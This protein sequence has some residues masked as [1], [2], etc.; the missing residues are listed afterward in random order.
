M[1]R[2]PIGRLVGVIA[3]D[4]LLSPAAIPRDAA[5]GGPTPA[6][7]A[8]AGHDATLEAFLRYLAAGNFGGCAAAAAA[9]LLPPSPARRNSSWDR[10]ASRFPTSRPRTQLRGVSRVANLRALRSQLDEAW[11]LARRMIGQ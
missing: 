2:Q 5:V 1:L 4:D 3:L 8:P 11:S 10:I 7:P 9:D 6:G